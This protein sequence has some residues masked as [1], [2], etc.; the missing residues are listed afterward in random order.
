MGISFDEYRQRL[1]NPDF[2]SAEEVAEVIL[3]CWK[4]PPRICIRDIVVTRGPGSMEL[5]KGTCISLRTLQ[6][7]IPGPWFFRGWRQYRQRDGQLR[8][9]PSRRGSK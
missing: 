3:F 8:L 1:G 6:A 7:S 5:A 2:L 4:L 9:S